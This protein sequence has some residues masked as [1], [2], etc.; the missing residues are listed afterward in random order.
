M[1]KT[2]PTMPTLTLRP[3]RFIRVREGW[4]VRCMTCPLPE[5]NRVHNVDDDLEIR[6]AQHDAD[7]LGENRM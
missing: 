6:Q 7:R 1:K 3:H 2:G 5:K 4:L